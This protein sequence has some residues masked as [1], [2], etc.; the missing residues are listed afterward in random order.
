MTRR[1]TLQR[2]ESRGINHEVL[3]LFDPGGRLEGLAGPADDSGSART[4]AG[5]RRTITS[6]LPGEHRDAR[7]FPRRRAFALHPIGEGSRR[8]RHL[9]PRRYL[10]G[11]PGMKKTYP[12]EPVFQTGSLI[13]AVILVQTLYALF[14]RP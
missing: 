6:A 12:N 11:A 9:L 4:T 1:V 10:K 14:I 2:D 7:V 8:Q 13:V 5:G 3:A